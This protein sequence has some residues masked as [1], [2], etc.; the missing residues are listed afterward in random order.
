[1]LE[2]VVP[3]FGR[4]DEVGGVAAAVYTRRESINRHESE[5][6]RRSQLAR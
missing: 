1:M 2:V 4:V 5:N 3:R 6:D